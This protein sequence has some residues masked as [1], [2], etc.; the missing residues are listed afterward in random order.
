VSFTVA[1]FTS[2]EQEGPTDYR[3]GEVFY[4]FI[5]KRKRGTVSPLGEQGQTTLCREMLSKRKGSS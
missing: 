2:K 3:K 5:L 1:Y 4:G